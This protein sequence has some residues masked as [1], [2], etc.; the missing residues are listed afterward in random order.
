MIDEIDMIDT[1]KLFVKRELANKARLEKM[2]VPPESAQK[3]GM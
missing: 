3:T 2:C 1:I